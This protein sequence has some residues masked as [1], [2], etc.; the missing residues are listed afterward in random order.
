MSIKPLQNDMNL[1]LQLSTGWR[2]VTNII[3]CHTI[4]II[5]SSLL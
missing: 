3:W 4:Y 2:L 5:F 1:L